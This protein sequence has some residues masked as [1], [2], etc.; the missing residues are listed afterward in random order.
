MFL[1]KIFNFVHRRT[2]SSDS[3]YNGVHR[4]IYGKYVVLYHQP[5]LCGLQWISQELCW[6]FPQ[7]GCSNILVKKLA[8]CL[9]PLVILKVFS[10]ENRCPQLEENRAGWWLWTESEVCSSTVELGNSYLLFFTGKNPH[11]FSH[12]N[13]ACLNNYIL[14]WKED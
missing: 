1:K 3:F 13:S 10:T 12:I 11:F 14:N 2:S 7:S 9:H 5:C 8:R 6:V 4:N